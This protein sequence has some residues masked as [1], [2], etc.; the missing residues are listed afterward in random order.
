[1]DNK[2]EINW[3]IGLWSILGFFIFLTYN[4]L[5]GLVSDLILTLGLALNIRPELLQ[6]Y[7]LIEKGLMIIVLIILSVIMIRHSKQNNLKQ[8]SFDFPI[9]FA[10]KIGITALILFLS[11][12]VLGVIRDTLFLGD[13]YRNFD[14]TYNL[15]YTNHK[16][17]DFGFNAIELLIILLLFFRLI[18]IIKPIKA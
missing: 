7:N 3:N 6:Y 9:K 11:T 13:Y 2:I 5:K 12:I 14:K 10:K 15:I 8:S 17:L 4:F 18:K 1:M 16:Y